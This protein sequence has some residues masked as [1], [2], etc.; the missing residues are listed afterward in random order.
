M[1]SGEESCSLLSIAHTLR[2]DNVLLT[3]S[4]SG[5]NPAERLRSAERQE[6]AVADIVN[7]SRLPPLPPQGDLSGKSPLPP[8]TSSPAVRP[9]PLVD[10]SVAI[11]GICFTQDQQDAHPE[12]QLNVSDAL[13]YL[14]NVKVQFQNRP[15]VYNRFLDIMKD[16]KS[17]LYAT[18]FLCILCTLY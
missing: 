6:N 12:R 11:N 16:F 17:Q 5:D 4:G 3:M 10:A 9:G 8:T 1:G 7:A 13:T 14:D 2:T 15:D 18:C